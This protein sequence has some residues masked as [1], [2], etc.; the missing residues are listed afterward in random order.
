MVVFFAFGMKTFLTSLSCSGGAQSLIGLRLLDLLP[1]DLVL[2]LILDPVDADLALPFTAREDGEIDLEEDLP[3]P[4]RGGGD[5]ERM[6]LALRGGGEDLSRMRWGGDG[7]GDL[8]LREGGGGVD[9]RRR[10]RG[11]GERDLES[12][13]L[14]ERG[15]G[16]G[17]RDRGEGERRRSLGGGERR[18]GLLLRRSAPPR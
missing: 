2:T 7:G 11:G 6:L 10:R 9:E 14:R 16:D 15:G 5:T 17:E 3:R 4:R 1:P 8:S 18:R 12:Y 13:R